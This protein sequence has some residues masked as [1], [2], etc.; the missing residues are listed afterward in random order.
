MIKRVTKKFD[1]TKSIGITLEEYLNFF[2]FLQN[3]N[4]VDIALAVYHIAG[5]SIDQGEDVHSSFNKK[6]NN[7]H[8]N[9]WWR[10]IMMIAK[11]C[12]HLDC[13]CFLLSYIFKLKFKCARLIVIASN[14]C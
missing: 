12:M 13:F 4:D 7:I 14:D 6:I 10:V 2:Q 11:L 9:Y 1:E 8:Y 5:A 3:I